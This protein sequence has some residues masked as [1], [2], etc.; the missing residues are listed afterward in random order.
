MYFQFSFPAWRLVRVAIL[1]ILSAGCGVS[2]AA[3]DPAYCKMIADLGRG[4]ATWRDAGVPYDAALKRISS[5][6]RDTP[7]FAGIM[8]IGQSAVQTAYLDMPK[9]TPDGAYKLYYV[10]CMSGG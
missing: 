7:S 3:K 8:Q 10:A 1:L 9:I 2:F 6:A 5:A 4:V